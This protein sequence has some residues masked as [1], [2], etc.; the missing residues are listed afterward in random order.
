MSDPV[1]T[2][3]LGKMAAKK[4]GIKKQ[5]V[6]DIKDAPS[7]KFSD[8]VIGLGRVAR[9]MTYD[10]GDRADL[11]ISLTY[12]A[13]VAVK[14]ARKLGSR[15]VYRAIHTEMN[16]ATLKHTWANTPLNPQMPDGQKLVV[17]VEE[18]GEAA[19]NRSSIEEFIQIATMAGA[20]A[21]SLRAE[22]PQ[23]WVTT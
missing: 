12:V 7:G 4:S 9:A 15:K 13:S 16:N 18:V 2:V 5:V 22:N 21:A 6:R 8:L 19:E 3:D 23:D 20:W 10:N 11:Y 17:L 14:Q 1:G